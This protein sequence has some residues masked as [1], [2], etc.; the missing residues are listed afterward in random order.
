MRLQALAVAA[1]ENER[2]Q[3]EK[4]RNIFPAPAMWDLLLFLEQAKPVIARSTVTR[5]LTLLTV[6]RHPKNGTG[7][8]TS[9]SP[10]W[11]MISDYR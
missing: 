6:Q 7:I 8:E 9:L 5:G 3:F 10:A 11:K 1:P 2:N 4:V